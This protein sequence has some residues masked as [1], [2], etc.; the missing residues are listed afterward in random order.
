MKRSR[1]HHLDLKFQIGRQT[2]YF[3]EMDTMM[4][5]STLLRQISFVH[6]VTVTEMEPYLAI[7]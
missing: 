6:W 2:K 5:S 3:I 4:I 7:K 1:Q